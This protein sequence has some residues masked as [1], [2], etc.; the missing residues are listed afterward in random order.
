MDYQDALAVLGVGTAH[1]GGHD[2]TRR[3]VREIPWSR[4]MSVLEVGCGTGTTLLNIQRWTGC[5]VHGVDIRPKMISKARERA[6]RE[7]VPANWRVADATALP[8][9]DESFDVVYTESVNV[10]LNP[11]EALKEYCRVLR[12]GGWYADVE[13]LALGPVT[14][15]WKKS[16]QDVYGARVV[17]YASEWKAYYHRAGFRD[18]HVVETRSVRP[19]MMGTG[20][21][22]DMDDPHLADD[23]AFLDA[24]VLDVL[25]MNAQW[26]EQHHHSLG[27]GI[28]V[29]RK[30]LAHS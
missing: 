26:M 4:D 6:R 18:V 30:P 23:T 8:F 27:Y 22:A 10:F 3:W 28:F 12:P 11:N 25:T 14:P 9:S 29:M 5:T 1:P 19:H 2:S 21:A 24:D 15:E 20:A 16:A 13:M 17:P 7:G